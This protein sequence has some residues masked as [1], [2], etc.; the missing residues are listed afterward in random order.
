[1]D[2][3]NSFPAEADPYTL[4]NVARALA[5]FERT[6]ISLRSPYDRYR[7]NG[8]LDAISDAAKL[9][10]ILFSSGERTACF[11]CHGGWNFSGAVA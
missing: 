2:S 4:T 7:F 5:S 10:E 3:E 9:G 11:Q 1:M 6:M 8:E